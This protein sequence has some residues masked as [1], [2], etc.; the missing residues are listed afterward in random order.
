M[1]D[2]MIDPTPV[3]SFIRVSYQGILDGEPES[4]SY[5]RY[6]HGIAAPSA[7]VLCEIQNKII[8]LIRSELG[9]KP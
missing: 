8:Q 4:A 7:N 3:H 2:E 5:E 6:W 9:Q 1:A